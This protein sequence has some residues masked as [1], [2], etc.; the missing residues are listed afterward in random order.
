MAELCGEPRTGIAAE[1]LES[2]SKA[3]C[4]MQECPERQ[5]EDWKSQGRPVRTEGPWQSC[6]CVSG[7]IQ[8]WNS[9]RATGQ[10]AG[11]QQSCPSLWGQGLE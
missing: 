9:R 4:Q 2:K 1:G 6:L 7:G 11:Y 8:T 5:F 3:Q 10:D